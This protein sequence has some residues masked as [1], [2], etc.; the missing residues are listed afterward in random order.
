MALVNAITEMIAIWTG[1]A[2]VELTVVTWTRFVQEFAAR[3]LL[4][5]LY[6]QTMMIPAI[7]TSAVT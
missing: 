3:M 7:Q 6:S 2:K 4:P 5:E 1:L